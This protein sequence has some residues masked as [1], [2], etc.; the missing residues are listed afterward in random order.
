MKDKRGLA[1]FSAS[2]NANRHPPPRPKK[3]PVPFAKQ[4]IYVDRI[5]LNDRAA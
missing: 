1:P 2:R 4:V 5:R 3:G